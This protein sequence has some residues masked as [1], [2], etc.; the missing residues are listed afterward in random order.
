[1]DSTLQ[2]FERKLYSQ[3]EPRPTDNSIFNI[4]KY[5]GGFMNEPKKPQLYDF[6]GVQSKMK[7][8]GEISLKGKRRLHFQDLKDKYTQERVDGGA[9]EALMN[10]SRVESKARKVRKHSEL[11]PIERLLS[12]KKVRQRLT[13]SL[14]TKMS[15]PA[16]GQNRCARTVLW[17]MDNAVLSDWGPWKANTDSLSTLRRKS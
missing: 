1:M 7:G 17:T 3:P 11:H 10:F 6:E 9:R 5:S 4:N 12:E 8:L 13:R 15:D 16:A 14:S 2:Q